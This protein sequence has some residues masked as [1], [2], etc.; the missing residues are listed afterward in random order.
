MTPNLP[1]GPETRLDP[2][3]AELV[4]AVSR[5]MTELLNPA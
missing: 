3:Y 5:T 2:A 4:A 1:K